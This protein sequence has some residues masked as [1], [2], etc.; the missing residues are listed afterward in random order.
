MYIVVIL[1]DSIRVQNFYEM[2]VAWVE[3]YISG[4]DM[5]SS[6]HMDNKK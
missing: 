1:L 6:L 4:D 2:K 5:S 3:I